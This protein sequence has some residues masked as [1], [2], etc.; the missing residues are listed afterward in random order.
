MTIVFVD[1]NMC[2]W[3]ANLFW[4]IVTSAWVIIRR[5]LVMT[6]R[7]APGYHNQEGPYNINPNGPYDNPKRV[8]I[9]RGARKLRY[10]SHPPCPGS[11]P[12]S[13]DPSYEYEGAGLYFK[14]CMR[15]AKAGIPQ[16]SEALAEA[17]HGAADELGIHV[18]LQML[19]TEMRRGLRASWR[20]RRADRHGH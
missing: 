3:L 5:F 9:T 4:V 18:R 14:S 1:I 19:R 2:P 8:M 13:A 10:H 11:P 12:R 20:I 16:D 17:P 15:Q 7:G 6:T